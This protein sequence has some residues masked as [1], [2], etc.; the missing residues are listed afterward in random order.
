MAVGALTESI[1]I[2]GRY[3]LLRRLGGSSITPLFVASDLPAGAVVCVRLWQFTA[4]MD[5]CARVPP[6]APTRWPS[7]DGPLLPYDFG[8]DDDVAYLVRP[9]VSGR[10]LA[11]ELESNRRFT[12]LEAVAL[13][14]RIGASLLLA[15]ECGF[16]RPGVQPDSVILGADGT[17]R[18]GGFDRIGG[19]EARAPDAAASFND[20]TMTDVAALV[21][22]L[23]RLSGVGPSGLPDHVLATAM[24]APPWQR[25]ANPAALR[26]GGLNRTLAR[27]VRG[28]SGKWPS[29][30][31]LV[32][33]LDRAEAHLR[34]MSPITAGFKACHSVMAGAIRRARQLGPLC[35]PYLI[36]ASL[37]SGTALLAVGAVRGSPTD[38]H[39]LVVYTLAAPARPSGPSLAVLSRP[40]PV[41]AAQ[42]PPVA[43]RGDPAQIAPAAMSGIH[44]IAG[45]QPTAAVP[46]ERLAGVPPR[47]QEQ[48]AFALQPPSPTIAS[49]TSGAPMGESSRGPVKSRLVS[50]EATQRAAGAVVREHPTPTLPN[51][52][53]ASS[54]PKATS[55]RETPPAK[56]RVTSSAA[57]TAHSIEAAPA[58]TPPA[59]TTEA[60]AT[61][62][63]S[64]ATP[65]ASPDAK[66]S[67]ASNKH[68]AHR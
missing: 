11:A 13:V 12:D 47:P 17:V 39:N 48:A 1:V 68:T 22:L 32:A 7:G 51:S 23:H 62:P 46:A 31:E 63:R 56:P 33:T 21:S 64:A 54:S 37:L 5:A 16:A 50:G 67:A 25:P 35:L 26:P 29:L 55:P 44:G 41:P 52:T 2:D 49:H 58:A 14:R 20:E 59:S 40:I 42:A 4:S 3:Q 6:L 43:Q 34:G 24:G 57:P 45:N 10:S 9:Y 66:S 19:S 30:R 15:Y 18:T 53:P 65:A 28:D 60:P 27:S 38:P 36:A 61:K 8:V